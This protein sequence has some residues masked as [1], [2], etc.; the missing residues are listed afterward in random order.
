MWSSIKTVQ[1]PETL[2]DAGRMGQQPGATFIG[3]GTYLVADSDKNTDTLVSLKKVVPSGITLEG[4]TLMI[5]GGTSLEALTHY[6]WPE[7]CAFISQAAKNSC[8]SK[9]I[10]NQRTVAGEVA[11]FRQNSEL[12][13]LLHAL[14]P[15]LEIF[16]NN[17]IAEQPLLEWDGEG[18]L[19]NLVIDLA[20]LHHIAFL[21]Y[22]PIPSAPPFLCVA[23]ATF[24]NHSRVLVGGNVSGMHAVDFET[25]T[26][27]EEAQLLVMEHAEDALL[28]DHF[29]SVEYKLT[30]LKTA[31]RR[32]G[33]AL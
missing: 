17:Q 23:G 16:L 9:N 26:F 4:K 15:S 29:G 14:N 6:K 12:V 18:I 5:G 25:P 19:V 11:N 21:R 3:G 20:E 22:A 24:S 7:K 13:L 28:A 27:G 1:S 30:L 32:L 2:A 10:R 31:L 33:E 8:P